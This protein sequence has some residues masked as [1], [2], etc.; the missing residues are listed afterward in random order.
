L[1]PGTSLEVLLAGGGFPSWV[2]ASLQG[3]FQVG[4]LIKKQLI[5]RDVTGCNI[6]QGMR[7]AK[8]RQ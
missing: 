4:S 3:V 5:H 2:T 6:G 7:I 8:I 1:L